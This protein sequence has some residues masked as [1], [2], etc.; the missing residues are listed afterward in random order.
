MLLIVMMCLFIVCSSVVW[1][2]GGVWLILFV[3]RML[4][5]IGFFIRW[6]VLLEK[7]KRLVFSILFGIR[8][9]VNW[10][11]LKVSDSVVV[12]LWVSRVLVVLGGFL[13]R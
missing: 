1:V 10:I 7:L 11:C 9:G 5:K 4:V 13:S 2:L 12:K 8:F 6:K 3:N